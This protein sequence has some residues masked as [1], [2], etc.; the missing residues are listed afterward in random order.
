[1]A[2]AFLW[3][4]SYKRLKLAQL[5]VKLGAFL[6]MASRR[7]L[8]TPSVPISRHIQASILENARTARAEKY[9]FILLSGLRAHTKPP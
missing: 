3:E 6:T 9:C 7:L 2:H 4:H 1:L 5:L 8:S